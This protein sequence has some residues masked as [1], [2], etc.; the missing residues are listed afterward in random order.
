MNIYLG[1][2]FDGYRDYEDLQNVERLK[3]YSQIAAKV[4]MSVYFNQENNNCRLYWPHKG[5]CFV[6]IKVK[7]H[8]DS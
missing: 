3:N 5:N 4:D 2:I 6:K 7:C 1:L 8:Q